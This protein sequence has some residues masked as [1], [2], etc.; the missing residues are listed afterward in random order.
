MLVTIGMTPNTEVEVGRLH[1]LSFTIV[2]SA[3][4][5]LKL[6]GSSSSSFDVT[7][8]IDDITVT[9]IIHVNFLY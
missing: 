5:N 1:S 8:T 3:F 4:V 2:T 7:T 9:L 6:L